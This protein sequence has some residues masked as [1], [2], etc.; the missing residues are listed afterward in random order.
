M[1]CP[2]ITRITRVSRSTC[3]GRGA[4]GVVPLLVRKATNTDPILRRSC[5]EALGMLRTEPSLAI[6]CLAKS[7]RDIGLRESAET[8]LSL[9]ALEGHKCEV[10]AALSQ[11]SGNEDL[12]VQHAVQFVLS[13]T[14]SEGIPTPAPF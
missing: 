9:F 13:S 5:V 7:L 12:D 10:A 3:A 6:P 14:G 11:L 8:A 4:K 2:S 1:L